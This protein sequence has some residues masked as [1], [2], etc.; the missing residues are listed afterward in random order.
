[1]HQSPVSRTRSRAL[2]LT[3]LL[4]GI[5][6]SPSPA[7]GPQPAPAPPPQ[8]QP[9]T[10]ERTPSGVFGHEHWQW[11]ERPGREEE[12]KPEV[13]IGAMNLKDGDVV[14]EIGTGT[15]FFAR[16]LARAVAPSGKVYAND[17][18]P[19]MLDKLKEFAGQEK[20]TNIVPVLGTETDLALPAGQMDWILLVDVYHEFQKPEEM[21][22]SI[23]RALKP[24]GRVALVEYRLEGDTASHIS[25]PHRMSVEQVLSEWEPAGF[26]LVETVET[27]P[28]QHLFLFSLRR[29]ARALP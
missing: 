21:L 18:Q 26:T 14:A 7:S 28:A 25:L 11:L 3:L 20:I 4:A 9:A 23:R 6:C 15:G 19:G 13:V 27:L 17:I 5:S 22:A 2:V 29:G 1:M 8:S 16:R 24:N 12:E 10:A